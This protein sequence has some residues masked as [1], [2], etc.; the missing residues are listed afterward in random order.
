M[1][2]IT[3]VCA[4]ICLGLPARAAAARPLALGFHDAVFLSPLA[5]PWFARAEATGADLVRI[6]LSWLATAPAPPRVQTDPFDP[7]Y[8]WQPV[9]D[10]VRGATRHGLRVLLLVN[11]APPW[12][13]GPHRP[14]GSF[15]GSWRPGAPALGRFLRA[16]ALRYDGHHGLPRVRLWQIWNEPNL[17]Q[18]LAPQWHRERGRF[19][20][21]SPG[22]YRRMLDIGY[23]AIKRVQPR[24]TVV[25]AGTSP[26]GDP[27]GGQ[28]MRPLTFWGELLRRSTSFDVA[29]THPYSYNG[30]FHHAYDRRNVAVPDVGKISALVRR[31]DRAG[32]LRPQ[33]AKRMWVTEV[34]WPSRPLPGG[35]PIVRHAQRLAGA[36][37][38]LWRQG[39]DTVVWFEIRDRPGITAAD[40]GDY[41][42]VFF[43][44]GRP[45]PA[46][47]SYAFPFVAQPAGPRTLQAW[48][49]APRAGALAVEVRS[50]GRWRLLVRL[51]LS[52]RG[53]FTR[54][55]PGRR[56]AVLRAR[57]AGL[58]SPSWRAGSDP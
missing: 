48:G 40:R 45:K 36:L 39:V 35:V 6:E 55:V 53:V 12:S 5:G 14:A 9:D 1:R 7:A 21:A 42:G 16:A 44:D 22:I 11:S 57:V 32:H 26:Y 13:E 20:P 10:A 25:T 17:T 46:A 8:R 3:L 31:A 30:P 47:A 51:R 58:T 34:S 37:F 43:T 18:F 28:R 19:L 2:R 49:R 15:P 4:L 23:A 52:R 24:A 33:G 41:S 38:A 56:G 27:P 29:A 54:R 50:G